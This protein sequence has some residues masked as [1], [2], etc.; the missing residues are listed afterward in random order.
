[1]KPRQA[2]VTRKTRET[3]IELALNLDGTG[4]V[5]LKTGLPFLEHMLDVCCRQALFDL[6][7]KAK[8]DLE[9][10]DHHLAEDLGLALGTAFH[11]ALGDKAGPRRHGWSEGA[12]E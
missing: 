8:G 12:F 6:S 9:V 7:V 10:D 5:R 11:Q 2:K 1:M 4:V 3:S